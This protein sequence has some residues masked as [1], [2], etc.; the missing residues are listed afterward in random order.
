MAKLLR[1]VYLT[2]FT[3][4]I[5]THKVQSI[6]LKAA[7]DLAAAALKDNCS[8]VKVIIKYIGVWKMIMEEYKNV[9]IKSAPLPLIDYIGAACFILILILLMFI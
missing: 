3:D 9:T 8:D 7:N 2:E 1:K 5:S 6:T 4:Q